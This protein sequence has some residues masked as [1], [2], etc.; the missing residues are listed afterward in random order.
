MKYENIICIKL[1]YLLYGCLLR[2]K[3]LYKVEMSD[4]LFPGLVW[5]LNQ[6]HAHLLKKSKRNF[7]QIYIFHH[8]CARNFFYCELKSNYCKLHWKSVKCWL[9]WNNKNW[10]VFKKFQVWRALPANSSKLYYC[11]ISDWRVIGQY[12]SILDRWD[13]KGVYRLSSKINDE[14]FEADLYTKH[15]CMHTLCIVQYKHTVWI[16]CYKFLA[17]F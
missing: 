5:L 16:E 3:L 17:G 2:K 15:R 13:Y 1:Q 10:K 11:K 8:F 7:F 9:I 14:G 12:Q 4:L 6:G